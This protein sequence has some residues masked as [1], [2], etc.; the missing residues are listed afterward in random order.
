MGVL[1]TFVVGA[2]AGGAT[3][4]LFK[5]RNELTWDNVK[6]LFRRQKD[7][8][9]TQIE[10]VEETAVELVKDDLEVIQGI[11]PTYARRLNKAGIFTYVD[12]TRATPERLK[13]IV[14]TQGPTPNVDPW[15][16]QAEQLVK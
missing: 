6:S 13:E 15:I 12:L 16:T 2:V 1:T 7:E 10:E 5:R 4:E 11:G 8:A 3:W 9:A 14:A